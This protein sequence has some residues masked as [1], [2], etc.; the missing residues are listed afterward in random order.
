MKLAALLLVFAAT[1]SPLVERVDTT[2]FV[3]IEANSFNSLTPRQ[4]ALTY[5]L[6][7]ASIAIDPIIY[8]Q[9]SRFGLRQKELLETVVTHKDKVDAGAYDRVLAFTKLFWANKGNHNEQT[10]Q[11]FLPKFTAQE[12][13]Q[14]LEQ[15]GRKEL[16]ADVDALSQSLFDPA[17]EPILTAKTPQPGKDIIESSSNNFYSGVKLA[18]LKGF[19]ERYRLNSRLVKQNGKL[20]EQVYR[21]SGLYGKYLSRAN[22]YLEK[23]R[24][25]AEPAQAK[26]IGD[27][28]RYYQTGKYADWIQFGIDWVHDNGPVDFANGFIENYRDARAAKGTMQSFVSITDQKLSSAML[29]VADNAQYFEDRAPWDARYKKQDAKPPAAKA[30]ETVVETGDFHVT[31]IGDNLPNEKEVHEKY[32]SK[33]F[34]F[35]GSSRVFDEAIGNKVLEEFGASQ[36]QIARDEKY[37]GEAEELLTAMHEVIG[38]GSGKLSPKLNQEPGFYL[39]EYYS[40]LEEGRADL[41]ALWNVFDPKLKE[42]GLVSSDEVGR[43]LY[44]AAARVMLTQLSRIPKGDSIEE[45]HQRD[46]QL[47]ARYIMAKTGAITLETRDGKAYVTVTDYKKMREG[48]GMLLAELMRIKAEGDYA[49]IKA[50]IDQYGVHF[51]P[52]LRDQVVERYQKLNLPTYWTGINADLKAQFDGAGKVTKVEISYPR[53]YTKQQLDYSGMYK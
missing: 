29:K 23:A 35:S 41:V 25:Y 8:D 28:I 27:L 1:Q 50:L 30:V 51:D 37:G 17:F 15:C 45:D 31:T 18:D 38:H 14:A 39:K 21:A 46:R 10:G 24:A 9:L 32:G 16:A 20:V 53:D 5:W 47:I 6:T 26:A 33:S 34:L 2:A 22:Q 11:K 52:A 7:Q 43:A 44:D 36:A 13:K 4:Q 19:N 42:L 48:V 40:T 3:Q 49:A 12:L